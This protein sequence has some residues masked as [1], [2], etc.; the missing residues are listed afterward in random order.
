MRFLSFVFISAAFIFI[1]PHLTSASEAEAS[2]SSV[3]TTEGTALV[4]SVSDLDSLPQTAFSTT[5]PWHAKP[6]RFSGVLLKDYLSAKNITAKKLRFVALNDYV[7]ESDVDIMVDGGAILATRMNGQTLSISEK[8][9][10][11]ILFNFDG[12]SSLQHPIYYTRSVWQLDKIE[13]PE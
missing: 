8:G 7:V 5:T 2:R 9:P 4:V 10:V 12:E 6:A 3:S 13:I 11:F 1:A